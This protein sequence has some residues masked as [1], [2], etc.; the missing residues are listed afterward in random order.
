MPER[1]GSFPDGLQAGLLIVALLLTE[2]VI[3]AAL[4]DMQ[5]WLRL[6]ANQLDALV[7]VLANGVVFTA[8]M[9]HNKLGYAT[10]FH[11]SQ[12]APVAMLLLLPPIAML[13]PGLVM[14]VSALVD[15]VVQIVPLSQQEEAMFQR[16]AESSLAAVLV[17][18]VLAPVL[19]EMLF[20]G[21]ILRSFLRRY[22]R[23]M[24]IWGSAVLF[25]VAHLNL[26]QFFAALVLGWLAG[27]LYERS[28]SLI[29]CIALHAS[30]NSVLT[31]LSWRGSDGDAGSATLPGTMAW[32]M[33]LLLAA[34]GGMLLRRFLVA[35]KR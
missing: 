13:L 23:G 22:P 1:D 32:M 4:Y 2:F 19:E 33:A 8:V 12:A 21:I 6:S 10:L 35:P 15:L 11:D 25:G 18:C 29:P 7:A 24:A 17:T 9:H 16:M 26:Y 31:V 27:W 14:G 28:R 30:Y 5:G 34:A 3:G 20:R